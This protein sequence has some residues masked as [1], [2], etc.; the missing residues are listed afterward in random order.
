MLSEALN[1]RPLFVDFSVNSAKS[2]VVL[3]PFVLSGRDTM[4]EAIYKRKRLIRGLLTVS[5][6]ESMVIMAESVV[7]HG[8]VAIAE[9]LYMW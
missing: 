7:R 4:T 3:T 8:A 6:R 1:S 2:T 9:H 5:G